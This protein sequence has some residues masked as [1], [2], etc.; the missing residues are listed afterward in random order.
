MS[1]DLTKAQ[2]RRRALKAEDRLA[3]MQRI[4]D[5]NSS[6]VMDCIRESA[7]YKVILREILELLN[8]VPND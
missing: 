3:S 6:V 5:T 1:D 8:E 2:W 4:N 7:H